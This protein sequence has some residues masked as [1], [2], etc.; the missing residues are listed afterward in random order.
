MLT[1]NGILLLEWWRLLSFW[2]ERLVSE[3]LQGKVA[4]FNKNATVPS[5]GNLKFSLQP[6]SRYTW[7]TLEGNHWHLR[8]VCGQLQFFIYT[9]VLCILI[10][11]NGCTLKGTHHSMIACKFH[12]ARGWYSSSDDS[13]ESQKCNFFPEQFQD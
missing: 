11:M 2:C 8:I 12:V 1:E 4:R 10:E 6:L 5:L 9:T 3:L 13:N 7:F